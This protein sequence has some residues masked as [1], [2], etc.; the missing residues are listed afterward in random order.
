M[1]SFQTHCRSTSAQRL[2]DPYLIARLAGRA[3]EHLYC[4]FYD[5]KGA[6]RAEQSWTG[7]LS[8][9]VAQRSELMRAAVGSDARYA[10]V[11]HNHPSGVAAPSR[12]DID[13]T[14]QFY[15]LFAALGVTLADHVIVACDGLAFSFRLAGLI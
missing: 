13:A 15:R 10:V 7:G 14:R 2:I 6:F 3:D 12:Q 1:E 9:V 5:G 4:L 11:A 8:S